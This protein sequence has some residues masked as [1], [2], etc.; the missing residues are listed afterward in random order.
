LRRVSGSWRSVT[1]WAVLILVATTIPVSDLTNRLPLWWLDKL[2][3]GGLYFVLGWLSG[4]AL[5]AAGRRSA[6]VWLLGLLG[7]AAFGALDELHQLWIPGRVTSLGDWSADVAG[8]TLGLF[9]G[10]FAW[11]SRPDA[12]DRGEAQG[13]VRQEGES[14]EG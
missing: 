10:T 2:V 12:A 7:L 5:A 11:S 13:H 4:A 14:G 9:A 1:A 3:H 6:G 8:A